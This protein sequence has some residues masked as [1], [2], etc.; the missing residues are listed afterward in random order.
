MLNIEQFTNEIIVPALDTIELDSPEARE[1]LLGTALQESGLRYLRQLGGGPALGLFQMEPATHD[2]IWDNFLKY[3][4]G[5]AE[6]VGWLQLDDSP[7]EMV[8]N[9]RYAAAMCR[10]HYLRGSDPLP[11]VGDLEGQARYWKAHYN[12]WMGRGLIE[13]YIEKWERAHR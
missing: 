11:A 1:L 12:T 8:W 6:R 5:L 9:M 7:E 4:S 10:V 3:R 2:D 13:H